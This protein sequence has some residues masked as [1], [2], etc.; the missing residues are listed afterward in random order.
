[1]CVLLV[2]ITTRTTA[3]IATHLA[4][5]LSMMRSHLACTYSSQILKYSLCLYVC[6]LQCIVSKQCM[7]LTQ[8]VQVILKM[9]SVKSMNRGRQ[10]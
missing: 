10:G 8:G 1:M 4:A 9:K 5:S 7:A 2:K 6:V 3:L